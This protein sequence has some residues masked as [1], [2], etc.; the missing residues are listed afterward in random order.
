MPKIVNDEAVY[1]ATIQA[2]IERGYAG[3][4]TK[5][6]A[7]AADVSEVT[8]FRKYGSKAQLVKLAITAMAEQTD[9][10]S[11]ARYTGD[12]SAD[13]LRV[14]ETYQQV[15]DTHG[16]FFSSI[17]LEMLRIDELAETVNAPVAIFRSI[18]ALLARYQ[19]EGRLRPE[20]PLH[21]VAGLLGPLIYTTLMRTAILDDDLPPIDLARHVGYYLEGRR[22]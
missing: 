6:I 2:V 1:R 4:T 21:A 11:A 7:A 8:L 20:E 16:Q 10:A 17:V 13:L 19:A 5:E 14:V 3:A 9:F 18:G 15:V 22:P 12:I